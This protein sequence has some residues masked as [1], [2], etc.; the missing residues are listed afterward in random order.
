MRE[1]TELGQ[2]EK[3]PPGAETR[4]SVPRSGFA[5]AVSKVNFIQTLR[6]E[7]VRLFVSSVSISPDE[8]LLWM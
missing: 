8:T 6:K 5:K 3:L 4:L 2:D 1:S 7:V